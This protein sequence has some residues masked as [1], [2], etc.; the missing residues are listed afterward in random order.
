M[1][2]NAIDAAKQEMLGIAEARFEKLRLDNPEVRAFSIRHAGGGYAVTVRTVSTVPSL[3]W[4][5]EIFTDDG[6]QLATSIVHERPL[7]DLARTKTSA[8]PPASPS[9]RRASPLGNSFAH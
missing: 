6:Q 5:L 9:R 2:V 4:V 3:V 7:A 1:K 8:R